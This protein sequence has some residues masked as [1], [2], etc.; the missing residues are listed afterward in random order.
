[1]NTR[2]KQ[3]GSDL[4]ISKTEMTSKY[5]AQWAGRRWSGSI[6]PYFTY[7]WQTS[8][9]F[10]QSGLCHGFWIIAY[11]NLFLLTASIVLIIVLIYILIKRSVSYIHNSWLFEVHALSRCTYLG[12]SCPLWTGIGI[13]G[14]FLSKSIHVHEQKISAKYSYS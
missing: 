11:G 5:T 3:T 6:L 13:F 9:L 8:H 7:D 2:P 12:R 14:V 10:L 4:F 1:M